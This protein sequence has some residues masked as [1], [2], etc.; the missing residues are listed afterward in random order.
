M[1]IVH[2]RHTSADRDRVG[3]RRY[4]EGLGCHQGPAQAQWVMREQGNL[5]I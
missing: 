3:E 4:G 2:G 5:S 1:S